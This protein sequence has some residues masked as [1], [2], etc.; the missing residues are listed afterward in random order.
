MADALR[1]DG[2]D[3][4]LARSGEEALELL[5]VQ[6]V[7]CILLDLLMPG[8][9][10]QETCR[11]IKA[12]QIVRDV[13]LV[14]L[15]A[16]EDREAMIQGLAAGADDYISKSSE[17]EVLKARVRVQIRRKQFEDENRRVRE[18]LLRARAFT[19]WARVSSKV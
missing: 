8:L 9:G 19:P 1:G 15:T 5:A 14:M 3:V 11:R 6:S 4:S 12:T 18:E 13:P 2:Y 17:F 7:D 16:M 10:G